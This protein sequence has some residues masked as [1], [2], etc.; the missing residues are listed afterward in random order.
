MVDPGFYKN[1]RGGLM[2]AQIHIW[3]GSRDS[4]TVGVKKH[5][6]VEIMQADLMTEQLSINI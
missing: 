3:R 6:V 5:A 1:Y 2:S 4:I